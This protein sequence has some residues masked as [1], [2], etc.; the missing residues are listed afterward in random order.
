MIKRIFSLFGLILAFVFVYSCTPKVPPK[1]TLDANQLRSLQVKELNGDIDTCY[2]ASLFI[3]QDE[4]WIIKVADKPSGLIQ[5]ESL[6]SRSSFSPELD[7]MKMRAKEKAGCYYIVGRNGRLLMAYGNTWERWKETNVTLEQWGKNTTKVRLNF[8]KRGFLP[9]KVR[10]GL[11]STT[12][13]PEK[14]SSE[15]INEPTVYQNFFA[16]LQKEVF[17]R[18]NLSGTDAPKQT[19]DKPSP[20]VPTGGY[21]PKKNSLDAIRRF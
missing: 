3:L 20:G 12:S 13:D 19:R 11:F 6:R 7:H 2:K 14:N 16:R 18:Q 15:I 8:V 4:G 10:G 9:S 1:A 17:I 21:T 5:A